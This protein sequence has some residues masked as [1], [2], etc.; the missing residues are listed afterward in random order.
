MTCH[1]NGATS[2]ICCRIACNERWRISA[3]SYGGVGVDTGGGA[4]M[5]E[6]SAEDQASK[7][8]ELFTQKGIK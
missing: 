6:G 1:A 8:M 7:I 2:D 4:E 3:N 5:L